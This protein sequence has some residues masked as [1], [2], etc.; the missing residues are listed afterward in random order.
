MKNDENTPRDNQDLF[1][2]LMGFTIVI[3]IFS[4]ILYFVFGIP[5]CTGAGIVSFVFAVLI[6]LPKLF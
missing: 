5:F 4:L 2:N 1:D 3:V 6:L